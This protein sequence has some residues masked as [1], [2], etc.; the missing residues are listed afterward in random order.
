MGTLP[1]GAPIGQRGECCFSAL[2]APPCI[3]VQRGLKLGIGE[4]EP[5]VVPKGWVAHV[6]RRVEEGRGVYFIG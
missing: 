6:S 3:R 5:N 2:G 4:R 1:A